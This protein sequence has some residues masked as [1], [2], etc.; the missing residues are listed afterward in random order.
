MPATFDYEEDETSWRQDLPP[1]EVRLQL[2][3]LEFSESDSDSSVGSILGVCLDG[4]DGDAWMSDA[5]EAQ[6]DIQVGAATWVNDPG[7]IPWRTTAW[8]AWGEDVGSVKV[9]KMAGESF[10][11]PSSALRRKIVT[12]TLQRGAPVG[13]DAEEESP[14]GGF[15][16]GH[17]GIK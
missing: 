4:F 5:E 6:D 12:S 14:E 2:S 9:A 10:K 7:D 3:E 17:G 8:S 13:N 11:Q 1:G 16:V 15:S